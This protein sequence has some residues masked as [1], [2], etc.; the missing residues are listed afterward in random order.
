M[1]VIILYVTL[2]ACRGDV[3]EC[4]MAFFY[5]APFRRKENLPRLP[6]AIK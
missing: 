3:L 6:R 1:D 4:N 5:V 2:C